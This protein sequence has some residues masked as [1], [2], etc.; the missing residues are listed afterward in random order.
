MGVIMVVVLFTYKGLSNYSAWGTASA[1]IIPAT[2]SSFDTKGI[3]KTAWYANLPQILLSL[4]YFTINRICTSMCSSREWNNYALHRKG[5]RV[6]SARGLQRSTHFLQL[7]YR[8]AIPL[9]VTSGLLHW[10]LS[11]SLFLVRM[12]RR[13][14][15]GV[16]YPTS[17]SACGYSP[18]SLLCFTCVF[19]TFMGVILCLALR[20]STRMRIPPA[21]NCSTV[22]SAACHPPSDDHD[23][24]LK[25]VQWGVVDNTFGAGVGHCTFTSRDVSPPRGGILYA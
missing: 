18:L 10:L 4:V 11:Q 13:D 8:W 14:R 9:T 20:S 6:T 25:K 2:K 21:R 5:L 12:D 24:H 7:P 16:R 22:I 1:L 23:A 17:T 3:L 19:L 15:D